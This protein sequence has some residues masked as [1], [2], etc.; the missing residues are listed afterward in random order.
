MGLGVLCALALGGSGAPIAR[1]HAVSPQLVMGPE[2]VPAAVNS[3]SFGL[4][5]C[6]VGLTPGQLCYDPDEMRHAYGTDNLISVGYDGTGRTI[7]IIDAFQSPKI[8]SDVDAFSSFYGLP[9][10]AAFF[11]QVAPD[12]LTPFDFTS[13]DQRS[14][15][16][17]ITLDVE[18]AHAI[19]P[20]ANVVLVLSKSDQDSDILSAL[21]Y[22][23]DNN[24]GDVISMSFGEN[25]S[26]Q[27]PVTAAGYHAAFAPCHAEGHHAIRFLGRRRSSAAHLRWQFLDVGSFLAGGRSARLRRW[28]HDADRERLF[29]GR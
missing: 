2:A 7:V 5:T 4:F 24:V 15:T 20:G 11:T 13:A 22:A 26:C 8:T 25:E 10:S 23:I 27:D 21:N 17:E 29:L 1:P 9:L 14:W 16:G 19:A 3:P 18:W 6:Q 28:R 12:G